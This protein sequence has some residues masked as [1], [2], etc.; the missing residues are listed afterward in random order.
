[1]LAT[2]LGFS[3]QRILLACACLTAS[4]AALATTVQFNSPGTYTFTVP[5]GVTSVDLT[6]Q[7]GAG[8]GGAGGTST[9]SQFLTTSTTAS[10]GRGGNGAGGQSNSATA[11]AV[12]PGDTLTIVVGAGGQGAPATNSELPPEREQPG[13][14]GAGNPAGAA[15][16]QPDGGVGQQGLLS[17]GGGGAGGTTTVSRGGTALLAAQ[18]GGGGGGGGAAFALDTTNAAQRSGIT[19]G[20]G[21]YAGAGGY[22]VGSVN[23]LTV[24]AVNN[25]AVLDQF[26]TG[27]HGGAG[28]AGFSDGQLGGTGGTGG[29]AVTGGSVP[30]AI[31]A[32]TLRYTPGN[33]GA[34]GNGI[35]GAVAITYQAAAPTAVPSLA[36]GALAALAGL[37]LLAAARLRRRG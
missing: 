17:G 20:A 32:V 21:A 6:A 7:G 31:G 16:M 11:I 15:G 18:G 24:T 28:G 1:M 22:C 29:P 14:G 35:D 3:R 26:C 10:G 19:G 12:V 13:S 36:P 5:A 27:E 8:G 23:P 25:S 2:H 9:S 33:G 4:S 37:V 34:G 30:Y